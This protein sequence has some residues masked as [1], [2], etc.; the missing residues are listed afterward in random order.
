MLKGDVGMLTRTV[1]F[2]VHIDEW[3]EP[4]R[5]L[6]HAQGPE[7]A[8]AGRR[9]VPAR[10]LRGRRAP[11][12]P[13]APKLGL[14]ARLDALAVPPLRR[15]GR[16]RGERGRRARRRHVAPQ[17]PLRITPGG[18]MG[19]MVNAL[20]KP[21][22]L[23]VAEDLADHIMA[24]LEKR[25]APKPE[26]RA[27]EPRHGRL[28]SVPAPGD[29][30]PAAGLREAP[31]G[32]PVLPHREVRHLRAVALRG[33]LDRVDGREELLDR[34]G[35]HLRAAADEGPAGDADDQHHGPAAAHAAALA[36]RAVLHAGR[37]AQARAADREVRRRRLRRGA[38]RRSRP[39]SS[40][41]SPPRC[42]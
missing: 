41:T 9:Q 7:R 6:L 10:A 24:K 34:G 32:S 11:P 35:H 8:D 40:T 25:H 31:R 12:S 36:D 23:P 29:R 37:R 19:P 26:P 18:P 17:L 15:P 42:R 14:F 39:T 27:T 38:A 28:R 30:G 16:A 20:M 2:D 21:L 5:V 4:S 1:K 3:G 13:A 33:H 22:M